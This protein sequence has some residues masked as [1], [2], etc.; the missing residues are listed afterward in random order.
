MA[1]FA[2]LQTSKNELWKTSRVVKIFCGYADKN[3]VYKIVLVQSCK[4][5]ATTIGVQEKKQNISF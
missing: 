2:D 1:F 4:K 3:F 5:L